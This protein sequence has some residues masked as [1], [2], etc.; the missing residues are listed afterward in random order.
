EAP[1]GALQQLGQPGRQHPGLQRGLDPQGLPDGRHHPRLARAGRPASAD[2]VL[3]RPVDGVAAIVQPAEFGQFQDTEKGTGLHPGRAEGGQA[4][5]TATLT[6]GTGDTKPA[7]AKPKKA[8]LSDRAKQERNL[9]WKLAAP[10]F[11]V[12]MVVVAYPILNA[13]YLS[14][15]R[16]R[17]TDPNGRAFIW[18][19]NYRVILSDSTWWKAVEISTLIMVITVAIE[20]VLG[21]A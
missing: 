17:L 7:R 18:F 9:G 16:Y 20:F 4:P 11:I 19:K 6:K 2:P 5:V 15:F 13:L 3:R 14:F 1:A 12:M 10:A 21:M 8:G